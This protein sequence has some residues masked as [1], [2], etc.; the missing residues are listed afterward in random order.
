MAGLA[1]IIKTAIKAHLDNL[2]SQQV[3]GTAIEYDLSKDPLQ[4]TNLI[5]QWPVALLGMDETTS[6][7]IT[8][9]ANL[10]T[11]KFNIMVI[12]KFDN[13][14]NKGTDIEDLKD[15]IMFEFDNDPTLGGAAVMV[16][17]VATPLP[18]ISSP[19]KTYVIFLISINA[20]K[21]VELTFAS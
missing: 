9:R 19:D 3:L 13:L 6:E 2:V 7:Y 17:A 16:E 1:N 11:Y 21:D 18:P 10:R 14:D 20:K 5:A 12:Q 4:D 15:S 8:N